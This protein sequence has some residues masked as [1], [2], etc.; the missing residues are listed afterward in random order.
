MEQATTAHGAPEGPHGSALGLY[1][2]IYVAL[3]VLLFLTV[4]VAYTNVGVWA[5]PAALTIAVIK[6]LLVIIFFMHLRF[7]GKLMWLYSVVGLVWLGMLFFGVLVDVYMR[8][9]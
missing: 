5:L 6:A 8:T 2:K 1:I 4:A 9:R 3:M 7:T